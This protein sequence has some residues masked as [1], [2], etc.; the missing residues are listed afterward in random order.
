MSEQNNGITL[1]KENNTNPSAVTSTIPQPIPE[2]NISVAASA[3]PAANMKFCKYC[4]G[5]IPMD[6]ILCTVCGR[7]V[8]QLQ[9]AESSQQPQIVINNANNNV[10]TNTAIAAGAPAGKRKSKWVCFFLWL[11]LG[12]FGAHKFYDGK[13]GTGII[14][15]LTIG[16]FGIGWFIDFFGILNKPNPYYV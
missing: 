12:L 7:Q 11:F 16:F 3:Q 4:G 1:Q 15:I 5:Q 8:E 13:I 6:A 9:S 10:N 14:Y 2:A